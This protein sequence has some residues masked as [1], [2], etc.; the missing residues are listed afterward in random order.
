MLMA[1]DEKPG[2]N[3]ASGSVIFVALISTGFY[4]FHRE[5]PLVDMRPIADAR[6]EEQ[7]APQEIEAR[8]WQDPI[9]AVEKFR[10]RSGTREAEQK[11]QTSP[12]PEVPPCQLPLDKNE[13][14][15]VLGITVPGAPYPEDVE[16]RRRTRYAV[17]AG[18][19][20]AGFGP[21][22]RRHIG[23]F[24]WSQSP[25]TGRFVSD[26]PQGL[27]LLACGTPA[28]A[29]FACVST[30]SAR[31]V[32]PL[33][34]LLQ[35]SNLLSAQSLPDAA[36]TEPAIVP[37]ERFKRLPDPPD[38]K[39]NDSTDSV[40]V[41]WLKE[42]VLMHKPLTALN[43]LVRSLNRD[44]NPAVKFIGPSSSD[45]LH[46]MVNEA[47]QN[48]FTCDG[49]QSHCRDLEGVKFYAYLASAP[50]EYLF[51]KL[52]NSCGPLQNYFDNLGIHLQRTIATEDTLADGI[53]DELLLRRI[54]PA[55]DHIALISEWDTL[56][57]QTLPKA[58]A[59]AFAPDD[60]KPSSI[61]KFTYLRGLDGLLPSSA[62]K[63]DAKQEKSTTTGTKTG[64]SSDF[65]KIENDTQ[66]L[67]RP[68]GESQYDY[69]RRI[70]AQLHKVD[71]ELRKQPH[72][73]S[74]E[75]KIKAIGILGG[76][77][78]DKLLILRALRPEFLEALFFTT[79]FDEAFTIKSELPFTR[80]LIISS[81]FGPNL[82][83]WLQG[84]I[85]FFRD[86]G[87]AS[88]FLAT[89]L[90]VGHLAKNLETPNR[91]GTDLSSQLLVPRLFEVK[92]NGEILQFAWGPRSAPSPQTHE[93]KHKGSP[94]LAALTKDAR[95][96]PAPRP[97]GGRM[98][99][100]LLG[101]DCAIFN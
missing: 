71:D 86:T 94:L 52:H 93:R 37:Y 77:V 74:Q 73:Q 29:H 61:H 49:T 38:A 33:F 53:R 100:L 45:M 88:A 4:F 15:L 27:P 36:L 95:Q 50:D 11:C 17:L 70:S 97:W 72:E 19:E 64:G 35:G 44:Q 56:Y 12:R 3:L 81:S 85:P 34:S 99:L 65:F 59:R 31:G 98:D 18:L 47:T 21:E 84:D 5:A 89:Q 14:T 58:V 51:G 26:M 6:L 96:H 82:S 42:D 48:G 32:A 43:S 63:E 13:K 39:D 20:R 67:E 91:F 46:E 66:S 68:I 23:Y 41:L 90:A 92:R 87:Q 54:D 62:G 80:N 8:L 22:D 101:A 2:T 10:D 75:K 83:E 28:S 76:D 25:S 55:A 9:G 30:A 69:L 1:N 40:L 57:G 79:D 78:F 24:V 60:P 7:Q 16:Q